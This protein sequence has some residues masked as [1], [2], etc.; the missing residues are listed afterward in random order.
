[1]PAGSDTPQEKVQRSMRTPAKHILWSIISR[2]V[3]FSGYQA[4][5]NKVL[6]YRT[7]WY[8]IRIIVIRSQSVSYVGYVCQCIY[9]HV[10]MYLH[11]RGHVSHAPGRVSAWTWPGRQVCICVEVADIHVHMGG[12]LCACGLVSM[13]FVHLAENT[14]LVYVHVHR[15]MPHTSVA[16]SVLCDHFKSSYTVS[17]VPEPY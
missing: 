10:D 16:P 7:P 6:G 1:M 4:P 17:S 9:V 8:Q 14:A 15:W 2:Q 5:R 13:Y 3:Y 12:Y 11:A